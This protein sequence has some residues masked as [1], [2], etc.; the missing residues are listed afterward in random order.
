MMS[1][2][3][4]THYNAA[5]LAAM[6]LPGLPSATKN[7][8][9]RAERECW[10]SRRRTGRGGGYEYALTS[11]PAAA[12]DTIRAR[13]AQQLVATLSASRAVSRDHEPILREQSASQLSLSL[14]SQQ[15]TVE[16]A[17]TGVLTAIERLMAGCGLSKERAMQHLLAS[18]QTGEADALTAAM[19]RRAADER[20]RKSD[21]GLPSIRTLKRWFAAREAA[22]LA[23]KIR[24]A[25]F[26][27]PWWARDFLSYWQQPQKPSV[28]LAHRLFVQDQQA[29]M[30]D[31]A[32][33]RVLPSVHAV[34]RF[35]KKL[36]T[37]SREA[38]RLEAR[39]LKRLQ[40]FV[41]R[42]FA[43]LL[44]NDVW[45]ADGHGFDAEVQH[46]LT[47]RPFRPEITSI[48][49]IATRRVV[50]WSIDLAESGLAVLDALRMAVGQAGTPAIFY[51]D[52]GSGYV[53][54]L[55]K[56]EGT[57]LMGR[58]GIS[59]THSVAYNSQARGVIE[60]LHQTLWINA[61]KMLPSYMGADMDRQARQSQF[62]LTRSAIK[63]GGRLPMIAWGDF[64]S[65]ARDRVA[66]YNT[67]PH[68]SL[69]KRSPDT[70]WAEFE[71]HGW[72][73][74]CEDAGT[75]DALFRPRVERTALRGEVRLFNNVYFSAALAELHGETVQV[76]YDIHAAERV[77]VYLPDGRFVCHADWNAN[78]AA[79]FPQPVVEQ[80]RD[81]RADA[82]LR[83]LDE[84]REAV[85]FERT[86]RPALSVVTEPTVP[87]IS[88][89]D[90]AGAF[91]RLAPMDVPT[92]TEP[93]LRVV[94]DIEPMGFQ[95]PGTP[96]LRYRQWLAL[97]DLAEA[98]EMLADRETRW[99]ASYARSHEFSVMQKKQADACE[100][101][102]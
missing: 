51:V 83:R 78:S 18:V 23:P 85:E 26:A 97:S 7:V 87:G 40:P 49:D 95:V 43:D 11:L 10:Q 8:I 101:S 88:G 61:A 93:P 82:A 60:R 74:Q 42:D 66:E 58:L 13:A 81:A 59:M 67:R 62:K 39:E 68:V 2:Q 28:E 33:E 75:L 20:G 14:T 25:D 96:Q 71:S 84:K 27:L 47:G 79:Y 29:R 9:A 54:A 100:A 45:S 63:H 38:G 98:G 70:V 102:A 56:D 50:G 89:R 73:A 12:Q 35:L 3:I 52:N 91:E 53:N 15:Q 21:T 55:M 36:G 6:R 17:R 69:K 4:K 46:P 31:T 65:F 64:L 41:R 1:S 37:V 86:G 90:I 5:E 24:H 92:A 94:E 99:L 44:P 48:I 72:Q 57:G 34:R 22:A 19:L 32:I 80:K 76:A 30:A 77:W 16:A